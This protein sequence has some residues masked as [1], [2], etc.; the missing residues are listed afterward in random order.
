MEAESRE[1][2]LKEQKKWAEER[3][4]RLREAQ[5]AHGCLL[6]KLDVSKGMQVINLED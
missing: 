4:D 5:E 6:D 2:T 1:E 3:A